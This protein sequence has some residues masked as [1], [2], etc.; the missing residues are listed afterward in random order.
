MQS[1]FVLSRGHNITRQQQ[2]INKKLKRKS[3]RQQWK[4]FVTYCMKEAK[5][6]RL[7]ARLSVNLL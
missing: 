7:A 5:Q 2:K 4:H 3:T 6:D 1:G